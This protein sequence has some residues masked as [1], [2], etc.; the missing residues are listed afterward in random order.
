MVYLTYLG[1]YEHI[2]LERCDCPA[3]QGQA[4]GATQARR[5][6]K[7]AVFGIMLLSYSFHRR[8]GCSCAG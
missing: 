8:W 1:E 7:R 5:W 4:V 2:Q 6:Q 3:A